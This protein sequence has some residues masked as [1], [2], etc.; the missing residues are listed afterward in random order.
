MTIGRLGRPHGLDGAFFVEGASDD[1]RWFKTGGSLLV[2]GV[3]AKVV[4]G[5]HGAGGRPVIKLDRPAGRGETIEV[6]REAL[7]K[8]AADEYYT[9]QLV[10][11]EVVEEGGR[12]LGTVR[13]VVPGIAND[14]LD[15]GNNLL[16]P[17]I[18]ACVLTVDLDAGRI[19]VASGFAD[20]LD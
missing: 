8:P 15:I 17:M 1:P 14:A 3:E 19:L 18:G 11:L 12:A 2:G 5:R 6:P 16:L 7:P 20:A 10:G 4:V 9:F 13:A